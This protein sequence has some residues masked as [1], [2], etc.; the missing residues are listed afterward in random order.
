VS[1]QPQNDKE[2]IVEVLPEVTVSNVDLSN[3]VVDQQNNVDTKTSEE[4]EMD[5]FLVEVNKKSISNKIRERRREKKV[6]DKMIAK[7]S[8]SITSD[9]THCEDLFMT[10]AELVTLPEQVVKESIPACKSVTSGNKS[11]A[12]TSPVKSPMADKQALAFKNTETECQKIPYNQKVE[13]DLRR[14]LSSTE[15][16]DGKINKAFDIQIPELSLEAILMGSSE[17]MAQNIVDL[18]R[19]AMKLRRKEILCWYRDVKSKNGVDDKSART[20]VYS[21]IN[22]FF[23]TLL[24]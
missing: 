15:V 12:G 16:G 13:Q 7:D 22:P 10:S 17:V 19:V 24:M 5:A 9:L 21:E 18:F 20:L 4:M 23:L 6:Q 3:T 1:E 2:A 14:E 8:S 11:F